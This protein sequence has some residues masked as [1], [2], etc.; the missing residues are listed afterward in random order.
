MGEKQAD[1][2]HQMVGMAPPL[3]VG[4]EIA[5]Q[6]LEIHPMYTID[7]CR[8]DVY[9]WKAKGEERQAFEVCESVKKQGRRPNRGTENELVQ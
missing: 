2:T 7:E 8:V 9:I 6:W 5:N 3:G 4:H 1:Q